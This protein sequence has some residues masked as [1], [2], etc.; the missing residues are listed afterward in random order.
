MYTVKGGCHC[1]N[2]SYAAE[3]PKALHVYSPRACNCKLCKSHGAVYA[4]DKN[5][6]LS[7]KV[8]NEGELRRYRQGSRI[9][10][11]LICKNCGVMTGVLYEDAGG[12]YGS[13]NVRSSEEFGLFGDGRQLHLSELSD[14]ERIGRWKELWFSNVVIA[15]G[16]A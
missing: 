9:A 4:S 6:T 14:E 16:G 10:D 15:Y 11:F 12:I 2:I 5:G 1:E 7:I 13:I 3:F 8:K